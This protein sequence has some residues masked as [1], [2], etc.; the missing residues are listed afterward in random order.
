MIENQGSTDTLVRCVSSS[1]D[2]R[3]A[4]SVGD[5]KIF[6]GPGSVRELEILLGPGPVRSFLSARF[7]VWIHEFEDGLG[8]KCV[9]R[10]MFHPIHCYSDLC[11]NLR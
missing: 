1:R 11:F 3:T 7:G 5:F 8:R 4:E 6:V 10:T 2:P 9:R